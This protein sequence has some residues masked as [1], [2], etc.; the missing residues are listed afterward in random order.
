MPEGRWGEVDAMINAIFDGCVWLLLFLADLFG[1]TYK[2]VNV[3]IFVV[4]WPVLTLAL[5]AVV[6][7]QRLTIRRLQGKP[8][9]EDRRG[10]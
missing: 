7:W 5:L 6:V 10:M 9:E 2:A 8:A 3:W 4:I 1:M